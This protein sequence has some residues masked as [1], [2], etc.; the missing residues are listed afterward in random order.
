MCLSKERVFRLPK[1]QVAVLLSL[2]NLSYSNFSLS[3]FT[4]NLARPVRSSKTSSHGCIRVRTLARDQRRSFS[5]DF[6]MNNSDE[7]AAVAVALAGYSLKLKL[8]LFIN[9]KDLISCQL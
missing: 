5:G 2:L 1:S 4:A 8:L 9:L 3:Y 7:Q 6:Q